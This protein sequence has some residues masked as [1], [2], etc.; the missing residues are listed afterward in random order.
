MLD[1][2]HS[3]LR[4]DPKPQNLVPD[5]RILL[6]DTLS[7]LRGPKELRRVGR[8]CNRLTGTWTILAQMDAPFLLAG[9][10]IRQLLTYAPPLDPL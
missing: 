9:E 2:I 8:I 5:A 7:A 10:R 4:M 1:V 6:Y 3:S